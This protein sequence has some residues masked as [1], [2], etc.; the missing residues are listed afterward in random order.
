MPSTLKQD[1][2]RLDALAFHRREYCE[3]DIRRYHVLRRARHPLLPVLEPLYEWQ[4]VPVSLWPFN[5]Q[6]VFMTGL[7]T[8]ERGHEPDKDF[9]A[10]ITLLPPLPKEDFCAAVADHEHLV[11]SGSYESLVTAPEK[12]TSVQ[13]GVE[14]SPEFQSAWKAFKVRWKPSCYTNEK[15]I[16]RRS[17][18]LERN[19]RPQFSVDW[20]KPHDRFQ[21]AFDAFCLH[22]S[23]YGMENDT[24]LVNKLSVNYT[25]HGTMVFIP[26]YWSSDSKRDIRWPE[27]MRVHR[28]RSL[29]KQG[30]ALAEGIEDRRAKAKKLRL[31]DAEAKRMKLKGDALH[32]FL[33]KGLGLVEG[34]DSK[35]LERLRKEFPTNS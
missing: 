26:A 24:P 9:R 20:S 25:P 14:R 12:F 34:T 7:A 6:N 28:L 23:L 3:G 10:L 30:K 29:K 27:I 15:G 1:L 35:R 21:A 2:A 11:Q 13:D 32:A 8:L 22:W 16:I 18:S 5:T 17:L 19:S 33:C 4:F 31:L